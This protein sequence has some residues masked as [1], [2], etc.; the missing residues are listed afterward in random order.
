MKTPIRAGLSG[1]QF[2]L[3]GVCLLAL[4]LAAG[5]CLASIQVT[6]SIVRPVVRAGG[7]AEFPVVVSNAETES[8]RFEVKVENMTAVPE[9]FPVSAPPNAARGCAAWVT[10]SP[11]SFILSPGATQ[12]VQCRLRAPRAA[13]GGY[14]ALITVE[15]ASPR[16][17]TLGKRAAA[18]QMSQSFGVAVMAVVPGSGLRVLL[19]PAGVRVGTASGGRFRGDTW[20]VEA[21]V[22]N[23]GNV[24]AKV[25]GMVELRSAAGSVIAR[26][27]ADSG[28]GTVLPGATRRYVAGGGTRLPDGV[29]LATAKFAV[30]GSRVGCVQT[31]PFAIS[32]GQQAELP[33]SSERDLSAVIESI[34]SPVELSPDEITLSPPAGGRVS[35]VLM[36][37][38]RTKSPVSLELKPR[39]WQLSPDGQDLFPIDAPKHG[40][41]A[42]KWLSLSRDTAKVQPGARESVRLTA[43]VPRGTPDGD[44]FACI[45]LRGTEAPP[46][47]FYPVYATVRLTVGRALKP[48]CTLG[49]V[50]IQNPNTEKSV[51]TAHIVNR[52]NVAIWPV[53]T[54]SVAD[55]GGK[56]AL[57][58]TRLAAGDLVVLPNQSRLLSVPLDVVLRP[59]H[60]NAT[61]SAAADEKVAPV[62]RTVR[63]DAPPWRGTAK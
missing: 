22:K 39:D 52:G 16:S 38:N 35:A 26:V 25:L 33:A 56:T 55:V 30:P 13:S 63:F 27:Q 21:L 29:Y 23:D 14:Y 4:S 31:L 6:P 24:H 47:T 11:T 12:V 59:G 10:A 5:V 43:S 18:V 2:F 42:A 58:P 62:S 8:R 46:G 49:E 37:S 3:M 54:L 34:V 1:N 51:V 45:R 48:S 41:S 44:Y 9:G 17:L 7:L 36:V 53:V 32:N 40:R 20:L 19:R 15:S 28:A 61:V 57:P 60:Y 50:R